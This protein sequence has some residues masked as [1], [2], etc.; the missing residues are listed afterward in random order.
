MTPSPKQRPKH[1]KPA[2]KPKGGGK[3]KA[4]RA[5]VCIDWRGHMELSFDT[6]P[7]LW[8]TRRKSREGG[9]GK[10]IPVTITPIK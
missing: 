2:P 4:V 10:P 5:W 9:T 6:T 7:Y 8:P 1:P 3:V